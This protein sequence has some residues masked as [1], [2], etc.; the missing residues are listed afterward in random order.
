ML[1]R[2]RRLGAIEHIVNKLVA[3]GQ[4]SGATT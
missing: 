3:V 1:L 4:C 2:H